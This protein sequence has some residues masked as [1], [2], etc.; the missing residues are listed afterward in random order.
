MKFHLK[1]FIYL[2]PL[3]LL[4]FFCFKD[5]INYFSYTKNDLKS[6]DIQIKIIVYFVNAIVEEVLFRGI[7]LSFFI[8]H[9]VGNHKKNFILYSSFASS[10][11]FGLFHAMN[12]FTNEFEMSSKAIIYQI[13]A[14]FAVGFLL[15]IIYLKTRNLLYIILSH[16]IYNFYLYLS[17]IS[18]KHSEFQ[19]SQSNFNLISVLIALLYFG[20]P[21][22]VGLIYFYLFV[23]K[24]Q[25]LKNL[26]GKI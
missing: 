7:I 14:S 6:Y 21:L 5:I 22:F 1:Y 19:S 3:L 23:N 8:K 4:D 2:F 25:E 16:F 20:L 26:L 12:F 18:D 17:Q 13:Y 10:V 11:L 9:F 15:C 24:D